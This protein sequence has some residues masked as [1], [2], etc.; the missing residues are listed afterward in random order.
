LDKR[1][2]ADAR[3]ADMHSSLASSTLRT[4]A[5]RAVLIKTDSFDPSKQRESAPVKIK[6]YGRIYAWMVVSFGGNN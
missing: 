6:P 4:R 5:A 3:I 2:V 1:P